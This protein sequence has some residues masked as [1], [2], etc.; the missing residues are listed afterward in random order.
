MLAE[1]NFVHPQRQLNRSYPLGPFPRSVWIHE[2]TPRDALDN[3][4]YEIWKRVQRISTSSAPATKT[5][6]HS[7][8]GLSTTHR[9]NQ[10]HDTNNKSIN[11]SSL[12]QQET[13]GTRSRK[14]DAE[15]AR[16]SVRCHQVDNDISLMVQQEYLSLVKEFTSHTDSQSSQNSQER[17]AEWECPPAGTSL[18]LA[19]EEVRRNIE[20]YMR[21]VIRGIECTQQK[22]RG[23]RAQ[24]APVPDSAIP[25]PSQCRSQPATTTPSP[26]V[27]NREISQLL[28]EFPREPIEATDNTVV[29][30]E[31]K[32]IRDF[33]QDSIFRSG[34]CSNRKG[35]GSPGSACSTSPITTPTPSPAEA[36]DSEKTPQ[37]LPVFAR[38]RTPEKQ[39]NSLPQCI[40]SDLKNVGKHILI[41]KETLAEFRL[42][43]SNACLFGGACQGQDMPVPCNPAPASSLSPGCPAVARVPAQIRQA[44]LAPQPLPWKD[45]NVPSKAS[46]RLGA[47]SN[48]PGSGSS[49]GQDCAR[50]QIAQPEKGLHYKFLD[51][52]RRPDGQAAVSCR[53]AHTRGPPESISA[54][55]AVEKSRMCCPSRRVCSLASVHPSALKYPGKTFI[56]GSVAGI[57][58]RTPLTN[59]QPPPRNPPGFSP[60]QN[61]F[62]QQQQRAQI[63]Y[64]QVLNSQAGSHARQ[65]SEGDWCCTA[66]T[67]TLGRTG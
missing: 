63:N 39:R 2:D 67:G 53:V 38:L 3:I 13:T 45:P 64:Q 16:E 1:V 5:T 32:L 12:R 28:S 55:C 61:Y 44:S 65:V 7:R 26:S 54:A 48:D 25:T 49:F 18:T 21:S 8:E 4:C 46:D 19:A 15:R 24:G 22:S 14:R 41:T 60:Y 34:R 51:N 33:L 42:R 11:H 58:P 10:D 31:A 35:N 20:K 57:V 23:S 47:T 30:E 6:G 17:Q 37:L 9:Q 59:C 43:M 27:L 52:V 50:E 66:S 40:E 62:P 29:L 36:Q 56:P